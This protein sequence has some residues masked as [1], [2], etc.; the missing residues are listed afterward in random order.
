MRRIAILCFF[1]LSLAQVASS[2]KVGNFVGKWD[3]T[4]RMRA[5]SRIVN[6]QWTIQGTGENL[7]GMVK[8]ETGEYPLTFEVHELRMRAM[9]K[10]GDMAHKVLA[11][12]DGDEMDGSLTIESPA[13]KKDEYLWTAKRN[14][15]GT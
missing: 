2:Q 14:K 13:G 4:I 9:F 12:L 8:A 5:P 15:S 10:V 7:K 3:V 1:V 6:E 11:T